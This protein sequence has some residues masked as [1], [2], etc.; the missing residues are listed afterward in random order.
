MGQRPIVSDNR[1][2]PGNPL[3]RDGDAIDAAA[4]DAHAIGKL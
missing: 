2:D 3:V 1:D 4:K